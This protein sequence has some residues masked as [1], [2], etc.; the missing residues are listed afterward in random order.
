MSLEAI[1]RQID[2]R[3]E[4][5]YRMSIWLPYIPT[6]IAIINIILSIMYTFLTISCNLPMLP[7]ITIISIQTIGYVI[8]IVTGIY[9]LYK[10]IKRRN[11]HFKRQILLYHAIADFL[12]KKE[13]EI[14]ERLATLSDVAREA[15]VEEAER[16][17]AVWIVLSIVLGFPI[18]YVYHFLT[19]D[20]YKHQA[21]EDRFLVALN[22]CL[23]A[24][25]AST[26][27]FRREKKI[28]SRNTILYIVLLIVTIGLFALYWVYVIT[29]DPNN[30]FEE[31]VRWEDEALAALEEIS[32]R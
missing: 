14:G 20:F 2:R 15:E 12:R 8:A 5:D 25:G 32:A 6:I 27:T 3:S 19:R 4:T 13:V 9:V 22:R 28:P 29:K 30:H 21:R 16:S 23:E 11:E 10:W 31:H 17:A 18:L 24:I 26:L 1:R 7:L